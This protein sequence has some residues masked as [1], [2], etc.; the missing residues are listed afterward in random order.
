MRLSGNDLN[1]FVQTSVYQSDNKQEF[2]FPVL[3]AGIRFI[4]QLYFIRKPY[5][6]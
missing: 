2:S 4:F 3:V 6:R 5:R 1:N